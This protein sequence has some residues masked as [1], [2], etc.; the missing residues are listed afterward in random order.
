VRARAAAAGDQAVMVSAQRDLRAS[1]LQI[2]DRAFAITGV[3]RLLCLAVALIGIY[4]AFAA[5][6]LERGA[7]IG[8][9]RC[10]GAMPSRIGVV[11]IGQTALL[12]ACAGVLAVPLGALLGHVLAHVI[13]RVSFGWTLVDVAVPLRAVVDAMLLAVAAAVLAGL[14]PAWRFA[15]MRPA[16]ALREA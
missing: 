11:V 1:S 7:E 10:L 4:A 8:L 13:N 15:R 9:L 12:G 2:F 14:Q 6:Q 5:V 16:D 3:M